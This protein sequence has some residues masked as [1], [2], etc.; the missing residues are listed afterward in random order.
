MPLTVD[1]ANAVFDVLVAHAG[2]QNDVGEDSHHRKMFVWIQSHEDCPEYRFGGAL[3]FGGK[4]RIDY[5]GWRV[6]CYREDESPSRLDMIEK[7]NEALAELYDE[8]GDQS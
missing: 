7:T 6:D 3:G 5:N 8:I 1:Q 4:F 2:Q